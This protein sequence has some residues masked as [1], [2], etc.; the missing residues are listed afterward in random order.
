MR[1]FH[2]DIDPAERAEE[3]VTVTVLIGWLGTACLVSGWRVQVEYRQHAGE[4]EPPRALEWRI[5]AGGEAGS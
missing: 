1:R 5:H 3:A 4:R 2:A